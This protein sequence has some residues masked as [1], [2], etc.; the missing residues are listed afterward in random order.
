[1]RAMDETELTEA[2]VNDL[3]DDDDRDA[4]WDDNESYEWVR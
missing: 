1:M 4:G 2:E 3:L